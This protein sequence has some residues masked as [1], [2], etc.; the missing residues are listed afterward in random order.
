MCSTISVNSCDGSCPI[1]AQNRSAVQAEKLQVIGL[2]KASDFPLSTCNVHNCMQ[3]G[4]DILNG[5]RYTPAFNGV[6]LPIKVE[7][8]NPS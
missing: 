4:L 3:I 2:R 7:G 1:N 6:I 5:T 8:P